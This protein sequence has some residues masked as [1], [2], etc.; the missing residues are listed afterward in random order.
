MLDLRPHAHAHER[1]LHP[2]ARLQGEGFLADAEQPE[3]G[4]E[5]LENRQFMDAGATMETAQLVDM[6]QGT[7]TIMFTSES[8]GAGDEDLFRFDLATAR[9]VGLIVTGGTA[10]VPKKLVGN[11][12]L[13]LFDSTG[14]CIAASRLGTLS[15]DT[16]AISLQAGTYYARVRAPQNDAPST[17]YQFILAST[18]PI[19]RAQ[20][21][22]AQGAFSTSYNFGAA[23]PGSAAALGQVSN[24]APSTPPPAAPPSAPAPSSPPASSP[25]V[26][27]G[28]TLPS[29]SVP[30]S[31]V[32]AGS[33]ILGNVSRS[34]LS[35]LVNLTMAAPEKTLGV[36]MTAAGRLSLSVTNVTGN[37]V[38]QI[39]NAAGQLITQ[40][41]LARNGTLAFNQQVGAGVYYV[42]L[43]SPTAAAVSAKVSVRLG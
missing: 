27:A 28:P 21:N 3:S 34:T 22:T 9:D 4:F 24:P 5:S 2:A 15:N 36:R 18:P 17:S 10:G 41:T 33:A 25:P 6:G 30:S 20:V 29:L 37:M 1:H 11:L 42:R 39:V 7:N 32:L 23:L 26:V 13:E 12:D 19:N 8:A 16:I 40:K 35:S 43:V 14:K 38:V 31:S